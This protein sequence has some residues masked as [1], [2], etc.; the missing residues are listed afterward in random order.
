MFEASLKQVYERWKIAFKQYKML[1]ASAEASVSRWEW[2]K[3]IRYS[4][5]PYYFNRFPGRARILKEAPSG[6][7]YYI[8]YGFDEKNRVRVER[9]FNYHYLYDR[10][11]FERHLQHGFKAADSDEETYYSYQDGTAESVQFSMP[12]RIPLKIEQVFYLDG[13]V[14]RYAFF[15]L[16]GYSSLFSQKGSDPDRLYEWLGANG[17]FK[18]VE[19]YHYDNER[20][21]AITSFN[22]TPGLAPHFLEERFSYDEA[23][24]L[25]RIESFYADGR[26]QII[27]QKRKPG[28]TFN[29]IRENAF[30]KMFSAIVERLKAAHVKEKVYCIELSYQSVLQHFPPAIIPGLESYRQSLV[31]SGMRGMGYKIF[32][33]VLQGQDWFF[34]ISDP[35]TLAACQQLEQEIQAGEKWDAATQILRQLAAELIHFDWNGILDI[36]P[37]FV[38]FAIDHEMESDQLEAILKRSA[39]KEQIR[40]WKKKGWL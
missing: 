35:D 14:S 12:P 1:K 33:P 29:T 22:E 6:P 7:G 32:A 3:G 11:R 17:R 39:S 5:R 30:R 10:E 36:T 40:E 25:D 28:Q 37:D 27:Y 26:K 34:E 8:Y 16:N 31:S 15:K 19:D 4:L 23:G 38:I 24:K 2:T 9:V 20:M 21:V 13:R 18:T